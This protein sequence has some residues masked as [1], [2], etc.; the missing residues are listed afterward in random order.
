MLTADI[1]IQHIIFISISLLGGMTAMYFW[2]RVY[3]ET[4][5]GSIAWL[6][7]ALTAIFLMSTS[8][9]PSLAISIP[10]P[11]VTE[12]IFVLLGFWS[13]VY[14]S[15]FAGAG[16]LMFKAFKTVP[17]ERLGDFLIE[18]MVFNKPPL[19]KSSCGTNCFLCEIYQ[20]K[21]CMG[22][23]TENK[24]LEEKCPVYL[25]VTEKG[26]NSCWDCDEREE[27]EKYG[28]CITLCPLKSEMQD[29]PEV[30]QVSK[31]LA[32]STLIEYT[33]HT[34]YED[35]VVEICLRLYGETVNVVLVSSEPRTSLYRESLGDLIDV[36]AMKF[37]ELSM[38]GEDISEEGGIIRLPFGELDRFFDLTSKLPEGC[39]VVL[40]PITHLIINK[41][42]DEAYAFVAKVAEEMA[43]RKLV[44]VGLINKNAHDAQVISRFEGLFLNLA[45]E[46]GNR[47]RV[48]KGGKEEYIRF[49][50]GEKFY[51]E[52]EPESE[53]NSDA[54][55][56]DQ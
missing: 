9:F 37:I 51:M 29:V 10:E 41:G 49:Y 26:L 6:L 17:R 16:F 19:V 38:A 13:A 39:A 2:I 23:L 43:A 30:E 36:G 42:A 40:E 20:S 52:Q 55:S 15:I 50:V 22:C 35:S 45:E 5:K 33:P 31:L 48:T 3:Y 53:S 14:T 11:I 25:C 32:R 27:C 54:K 8:I 24:Y 18:G 12:T 28:E 4:Q 21:A 47:I 34:R 56:S 44:L 46:A 1:T 7:L